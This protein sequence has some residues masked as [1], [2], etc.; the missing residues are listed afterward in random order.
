MIVTVTGGCGYLGSPLVS[1]LL[2]RG[3]EVRVIDDLTYGDAGLAPFRGHARLSF[4][5]GDICNI[6]DM[7]KV[8]KG[9]HAVVAL[10][11]IVGD[12]ACALSEEET[13]SV[14]YESTKILVELC[15]YYHVQRLLFASSC[16]VYGASDGLTLNE[17]SWLN[18]QSLYAR[19]RIM[20]E[21]V[22]LDQAADHLIPTIFRFSTLYGQSPRMRYD[23]SVNIMTARAAREGHIDVFGGEQW[24][25][26]LHVADAAEAC[27]QALAAEPQKL[28]GEIYN[29]GSNDQNHTLNDVADVIAAEVP[30]VEVRRQGAM[31]D[32]RDYRVSFDKIEKLLGFRPRHSVADGVRDMAAALRAGGTDYRDDVY[33]NVKYLYRDVAATV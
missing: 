3:H 19:T 27:A 6:R 13:L 8:I 29:V 9:S 14:N 20:S 11:A 22:V 16:S 12:P 30:G 4:Q 5:R 2:E 23:L 18:P 33:Y 15:N 31:T 10:A 26:F 1:R 28:Q 17:G 25:P 32:P 7:V 21:K 24:R